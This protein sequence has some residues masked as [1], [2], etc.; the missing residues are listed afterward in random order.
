MYEQMIMGMEI[1]WLKVNSKKVNW[2]GSKWQEIN[3]KIRLTSQR[4][5]II[6]SG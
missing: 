1:K 6:V 2:Q 5:M 4:L 3:G